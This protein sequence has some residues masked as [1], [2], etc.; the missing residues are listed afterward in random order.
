MPLPIDIMEH[1]LGSYLNLFRDCFTEPQWQHFVTV[2]LALMQCEEHRTLSGLL[3]K[4]AG[5]GSRVDGLSHFFKRSPWPTTL[6]VKRWWEHYGQMLG[7]LVVAEHA[8]QRAL[9]PKRRGRPRKTVVTGFLIVDD[10]THEKRK[11]KKMEGLGRHYSSTAKKPVTGHSLFVSLYVLLGRRCPLE[12]QLYRQKAVCDREKVPFQSK[13]DLAADVIRTFA[14]FADTQTHILMDSWYTCRRLWR[15]ALGRSW[16]ITGGLKSNRKMRVNVPGQG[17][18]YRSLA[19]YTARLTADDF[20]TVAWPHADGSARPVVAH[21][22]KTFVKKLGACQVLIVREHLDQPLAHARFWGTSE[23][24]AD[25]ATVVG[26]AA[27]RWTIEQF[28]AD[29]KEE[30]GTD[31]YQIRSAIGI[32]RFWH[33]AFLGYLYLEAERLKRPDA[34]GEPALTIGQTRCWQQKRH[35]L[36]LL[37][38]I[39]HRYADGLTSE[40]IDRLLVA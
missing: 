21:L 9:R 24:M 31:H 25:L 2:L 37:D 12:P 26:W 16:A 13:V 35:Q 22:V 28:I 15:A 4:V 11:G 32:V 6:L 29:V 14:P 7:P 33:L 19:E 3:R 30:F 8:R 38:W 17:R 18:V 27:Q 23:L 39:G 20:T 5:V 36:L 34:P 40:Q 10:S 1:A